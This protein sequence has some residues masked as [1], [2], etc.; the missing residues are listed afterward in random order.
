MLK[1]SKIIIPLRA[2]F[3]KG[4]I[5]IMIEN[6]SVTYES[7]NIRVVTIESEQVIMAASIEK[8]ECE[9]NDQEW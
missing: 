1:V 8:I 5:L 6:F 2:N 3:K 9:H 7:P 4:I